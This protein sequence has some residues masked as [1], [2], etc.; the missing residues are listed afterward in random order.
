M[1]YYTARFISPKERTACLSAL[2]YLTIQ[3]FIVVLV[4]ELPCL[5]RRK[6]K[7][8]ADKQIVMQK[9]E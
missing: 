6:A 2:L 7:S 1:Y 4:S 3:I 5:P 9:T 8:T